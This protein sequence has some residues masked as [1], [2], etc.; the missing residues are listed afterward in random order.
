MIHDKAILL[1]LFGSTDKSAMV[2][3]LEPLEK[4]LCTAIPGCYICHCLLSSYI[5]KKYRDSNTSEN[6]LTEALDQLAELGI[7]Q[8]ILHQ[9]RKRG[10]PGIAAPQFCPVAGRNQDAASHLMSGRRLFAEFH[11]LGFRK[12][13]LLPH[14]NTCCSIIYPYHRY[15]HRFYSPLRL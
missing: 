4:R 2:R 3:V 11:P 1:P 14:L 8:L 9:N 10:F 13:K 5:L 12:R 6:S 7:S 15:V